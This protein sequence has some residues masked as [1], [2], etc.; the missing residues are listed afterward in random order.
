M[1]NVIINYIVA[2]I[3]SLEVIS[4]DVNN[5]ILHVFKIQHEMR[6]TKRYDKYLSFL[7]EKVNRRAITTRKIL[8]M[9]RNTHIHNFNKGCLF[10]FSRK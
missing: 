2:T 6:V 10:N 8:I 7:V 4:I 3:M 1:E 9:P 5:I